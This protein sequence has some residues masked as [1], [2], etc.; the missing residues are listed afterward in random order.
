MRRNRAPARKRNTEAERLENTLKLG[1]GSLARPTLPTAARPLGSPNSC[2]SH[3]CIFNN[4][5]RPCLHGQA[6]LRYAG[7]AIK[8]AGSNTATWDLFGSFRLILPSFCRNHAPRLRNSCFRASNFGDQPQLGSKFMFLACHFGEVTTPKHD[9][10]PSTTLS[11]LRSCFS[12]AF[13]TPRRCRGTPSNTP[14]KGGYLVPLHS[15]QEG[16]ALCPPVTPFTYNTLQPL[17][18]IGGLRRVPLSCHSPESL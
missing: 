10:L 11:A 1:R 18:R 4:F 9:N 12:A 15:D 5:L 8:I 7:R 17:T 14:L 6:S 13:R 16:L 3:P 2:S